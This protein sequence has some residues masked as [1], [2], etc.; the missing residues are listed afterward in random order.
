M[1]AKTTKLIRHRAV[2]SREGPDELKRTW[3]K[4]PRSERHK[5]RAEWRAYIDERK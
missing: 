5:L 4:T 3:K 2:F 1:N